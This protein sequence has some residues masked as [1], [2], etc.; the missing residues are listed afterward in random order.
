[1]QPQQLEGRPRTWFPETAAERAAVHRQ[2]ERILASPLFKN[3]KRYPNLLRYVV[4][5]SLQ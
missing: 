5:R 4:E 3:S 1:M 2:L